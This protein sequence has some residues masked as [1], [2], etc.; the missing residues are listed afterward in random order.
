MGGLC[1]GCLRVVPDSLFEF[2]HWDPREKE[3]GISR[4]GLARPW[5][6][7]AAELL[8]CVMLSARIVIESCTREY[9]D[10]SVRPAPC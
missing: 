1:G 4:D 6:A 7:V 3:F 2:H 8:K 10:W 9:A 5:D